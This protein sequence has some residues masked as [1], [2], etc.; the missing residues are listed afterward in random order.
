MREA[1][2]QELRTNIEAYRTNVVPELSQSTSKV[3]GPK[4]P[5][6]IDTIFFGGGTPSLAEV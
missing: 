2:L 5:V 4:S 6:I 1:L 3:R